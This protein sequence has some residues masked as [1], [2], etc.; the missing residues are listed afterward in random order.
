[1]K[2]HKKRICRKSIAR[3]CFT[4]PIVEKALQT[5]DIICHEVQPWTPQPFAV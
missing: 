1:M 2:M 3:Q 5:A 4:L